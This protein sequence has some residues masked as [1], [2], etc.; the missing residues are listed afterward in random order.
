MELYILNR[1][2]ERIGIVSEYNALI[3]TTNLWSHGKVLIKCTPDPKFEDAV[4]L[5]RSDSDEAMYIVRRYLVTSGAEPRLELEAV[6]A[7]WMFSKRVNW[8][9]HTFNGANLAAA[10]AT[11]TT[12]A[13]TTYAGVA[14]TIA[15]MLPLVDLTGAPHNITKQ[16]SWGSVSDAVF[17]MCKEAGFGFGVRYA[18]SGLEPYIRRGVDRSASVVFS[19]E[20][21]D[22]SGA[23]VDL[24]ESAYANLAVVGGQGDLAARIVTQQRVDVESELA[25]MWVD[26]K[27]LSSE[28]LTSAEYLVALKQRGSESLAAAPITRSFE[29]TVTEDRY[30]YGFDYSLGD[31][32]AYRAM[33]YEG[34]D[35]L[36]EVTETFEAGARRIDLALGKTAPTIRQLIAR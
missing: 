26:A 10:A 14:R 34:T 2:L 20:Y 27:D 6:G 12:D 9:T 11:L 30:T 24:D 29:A 4:F 3:W 5:K 22:V 25:E 19:T 17:E 8:W 36:S 35:V 13:Q 31:T 33:G 21:F 15:G 7:T 18:G 28:S 32:V 16:V 1:E 23:D